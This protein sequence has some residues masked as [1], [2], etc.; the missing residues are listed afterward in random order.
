[1]KKWLP[2]KTTTNSKAEYKNCTL[3]MTK[4]GKIDILFTTKL[5]RLKNNTLWG[6]TYINSPCKDAH[7]KC[8]GVDKLIFGA[9]VV[10]QCGKTSD[11]YFAIEKKGSALTS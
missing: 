8:V 2:F 6:R 5:K 3:F 1:M 11:L 7:A 4:I 9:A 10:V